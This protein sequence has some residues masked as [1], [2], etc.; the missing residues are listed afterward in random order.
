MGFKARWAAW[1][2][3]VYEQVVKNQKQ[4][5]PAVVG[6]GVGQASNNPPPI[7]AMYASIARGT[8]TREQLLQTLDEMLFA[9]LD[10]TMGNLSWPLVFLATHPAV[11][12]E[13]RA[14][15]QAH[16]SSS[17]KA[18][19]A[20]EASSPSR[21]TYL[22]SAA[23]PSQTSLLAACILESSRL[24]PLACILSPAILPDAARARRV[25]Y[26]S[27]HE[28]SDGCVCVE[29]SGSVLG[30]GSREVLGQGDGWKGYRDGAKRDV[31]YK[32]WRFGMGPRSCLGKYV[33]EL[34]LR[35]VVVELV[36]RWEVRMAGHEGKQEGDMDWPWDDE[37]WIHHP[38]LMLE[39][40][41]VAK[42]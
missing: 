39:C 20:L 37:M 14:E 31:R 17:P 6:A 33:A 25:R 35:S 7:I 27:R 40:V 32:Y 41:P 42:T 21:N 30:R 12:S 2:D 16:S 4:S 22:L 19:S 23:T 1:N 36:E 3:A 5:Q 15:I 29:Y 18:S 13:L 38:D 10:V 26:P 28:V 11:Q 8:I 9:N 24:R 34:V